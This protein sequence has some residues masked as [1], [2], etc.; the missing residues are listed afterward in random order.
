MKRNS[1]YRLI[2]IDFIKKY[3]FRHKNFMEFDD[4][5]Y[6]KIFEKFNLY[7]LTN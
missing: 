2:E 4:I 3:L 7:F 5:Y 1:A 6:N